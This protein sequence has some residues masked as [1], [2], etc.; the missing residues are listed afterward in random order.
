[1]SEQDSKS[2]TPDEKNIKAEFDRKL[3]NTESK[4]TEIEKQNKSLSE[5]LSTLISAISTPAKAQTQDEENLSSM[6]YDNP[7][8]FASTIEERISKKVESV[9]NKNTEE[10]VKRNTVIA[11]LTSNYPELSQGDSALTKKALELY[12]TLSQEERSNPISYKYAVTQAA[13][14][15]GVK[16]KSQ[17]SD[18][19]FVMSSGG[20]SGEAP[21]RRSKNKDEIPDDVARVA[22]M[23]G[24]DLKDPKVKERLKKYSNYNKSDWMTFKSRDE[25]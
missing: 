18:D 5:K 11:E 6:I 9:L 21:R 1:M 15:L 20:T 16:P 14:E 2:G 23:F 3:G 25:E 12:N 7:D 24:R 4:L 13:S 19:D 8:K 10:N 22:A 17:R